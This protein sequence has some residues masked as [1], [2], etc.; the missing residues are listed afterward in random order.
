MTAA[1]RPHRHLRPAEVGREGH[2]RAQRVAERRQRFPVVAVRRPDQQT[3][4]RRR[5]DAHEL[6]HV[7]A[8]ALRAIRMPGSASR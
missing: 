2:D 8:Q 4:G 6:R 5:R 3:R 7:S 1:T